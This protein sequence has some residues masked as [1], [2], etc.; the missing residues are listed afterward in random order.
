MLHHKGQQLPPSP[1][2]P[3]LPAQ[4]EEAFLSH[5]GQQ[6]N[7]GLGERR[8][9]RVGQHLRAAGVVGSRG[10]SDLPGSSRQLFHAAVFDP[11]TLIL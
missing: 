10:G 11:K 6:V 3:P 8:V 7:A 1:R 9:S 5:E 2:A 4:S